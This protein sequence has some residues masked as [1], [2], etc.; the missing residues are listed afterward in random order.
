[1]LTESQKR[2]LE[3]IP[4]SSVAKVHPWDSEIAKFARNLIAQLHAAAPDLEV[5][6]SGALALGIS[7]QNDIDLSLLSNSEDLEKYMSQLV[8]ILGEPQ[9]KN[10]RSV[11]W[12][13]SKESHR[14]DA[15]LAE[16]NSGDIE[17]HKKMFELLQGNRDLLS[18]YQSIKEVANGLPF[19]E[20]QARKYE[21]YNRIL[22]LE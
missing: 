18:E 19:R 10:K 7:G 2:Y 14:I 1:M 5:F 20:Y 21:F 16:R 15:Y 11:L 13:T 4:E 17:A 12:R 6:W 22:G 3:T 9:K 8:P